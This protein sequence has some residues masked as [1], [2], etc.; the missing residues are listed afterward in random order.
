MS[1]GAISRCYFFYKVVRN[2]EMN[3]FTDFLFFTNLSLLVIHELDAIRRKEWRLFI[4]LKD[5]KDELAYQ[6]FALLHLPFLLLIFWFL[7][8]ESVSSQF[9]FQVVVDIF[10]IIHLGLHLL[11]RDHEHNHFAGK[12][13]KRIIQSMAFFGAA[14][15]GL[16][17]IY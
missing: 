5:L 12:F 15:L 4:F 16:N 8:Q 13:S 2:N 7:T 11:L 10:L 9:Y 17:M 3:K 6:I 14:H 1:T